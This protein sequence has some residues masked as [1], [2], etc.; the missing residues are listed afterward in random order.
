VPH[1]TPAELG[2]IPL[3]D[4]VALRSSPT[5]S[6]RGSRAPHREPLIGSTAVDDLRRWEYKVVT[7]KIAGVPFMEQWLNDF[8]IA[9]WELLT[10]TTTVKTW[11]NIS[12]N[13]LVAVFRRPSTELADRD[14]EVA[15]LVQH[16]WYPDP[17]KVH[18]QRYWDGTAWSDRV[19][20]RGFDGV[21]P[22]STAQE[23]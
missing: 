2:R 9:G 7:L 10:L 15:L 6:A 21:D 1:F 20:D 11:A 8:G 12:G 14:H 19:R 3:I 22:I 4:F 18:E 23:T 13:D 17:L 5:S 16:G